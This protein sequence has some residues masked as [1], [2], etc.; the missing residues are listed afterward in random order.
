MS[1]SGEERCREAAPAD[2]VQDTHRPPHRPCCSRA[3]EAGGAAA[4]SRLPGQR[5]CSRCDEDTASLGKHG[6]KRGTE[7]TRNTVTV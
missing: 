6:D 5:P 1:S 4:G 3:P 7:S 2:S